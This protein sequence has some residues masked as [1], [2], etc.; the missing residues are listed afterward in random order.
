MASWLRS[1]LFGKN[2]RDN[3]VSD[4]GIVSMREEKGGK[5]R[6]EQSVK[7]RL[8]FDGGHLGESSASPWQELFFNP[9]YL[10][11]FSEGDDSQS[12]TADVSIGPISRLPLKLMIPVMIAGI[13]Y[14]SGG[15]SEE[16]KRALA[17]GEIGRASCRE[18]V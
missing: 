8:W 4:R 15:V 16:V 7:T 3:R 18:R 10:S 17:M 9:V 1:F 12:I 6:A 14:G 5:V 2:I 11:R 13:G